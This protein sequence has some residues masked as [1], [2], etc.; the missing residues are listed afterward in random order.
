MSQ[1][2][3]KTLQPALVRSEEIVNNIGHNISSFAALSWQRIR[4]TA[5]RLATARPRTAQGEQPKQSENGHIGGIPQTEMQRAERVVD[6]MGQR[7]G[8]F[9]SN[10]GLQ[11]R[12][13]AAYAREG[14]EDILAE[15]QHIRSARSSR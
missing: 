4:Q 8:H 13:M 14:A 12:K 7:L 1:Q 10:V 5:T 6:D 11:V 9:A 2:E 3:Q 15:A